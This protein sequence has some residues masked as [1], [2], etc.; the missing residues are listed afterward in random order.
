MLVGAAL[1]VAQVGAHNI[2]KLLTHGDGAKLANM[3]PDSRGTAAQF[4]TALSKAPILRMIEYFD[5]EKYRDL[6]ECLLQQ[7]DDLDFLQGLVNT[8]IKE[9]S[10]NPAMNALNDAFGR[11][12]FSKRFKTEGRSL[13]LDALI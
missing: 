13:E 7:A 3:R 4:K 10:L 12:R 2:R 9:P 6:K 8:A 1:L 5:E 11:R